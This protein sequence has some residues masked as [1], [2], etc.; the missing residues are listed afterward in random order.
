MWRFT[1]E[2]AAVLKD[3]NLNFETTKDHSSNQ[4]EEIIFGIICLEMDDSMTTY[5]ARAFKITKYNKREIYEKFLSL[6]RVPAT[7]IELLWS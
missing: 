1:K 6:C 2:E 5:T 4:R 7:Y 3:K